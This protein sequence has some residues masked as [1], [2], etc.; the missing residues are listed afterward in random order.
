MKVKIT[1]FYQPTRFSSAGAIA[2]VLLGANLACTDDAR[3]DQL[4]AAQQ[5]PA[6]Q[7]TAQPSDAEQSAIGNERPT[8]GK[9]G[10]SPANETTD[11]LVPKVAEKTPPVSLPHVPLTGDPPE[12]NEPKAE[13]TATETAVGFAAEQIDYFEKHIRPVL[14][15]RCYECHSDQAEVASGGLRVDTRSGLLKGGITGPAVVPG[16]PQKSLILAAI[17]HVDPDVAMPPKDSGEKLPEAVAAD[18]ERWIKMGAPDPRAGNEKAVAYDTE[19]AKQWWAFQPVVLPSVPTTNDASWPLTDIDRYILAALEQRGLTPVADAE[20]STLLRRVYLDLIGLPPSIE[21]QEQFLASSDPKAFER[22]VNDLL[23]RRQFGE[24]WG[25][26][27]LDVA[28][29]AET[30]GR[31]VNLTMPEA[32]RY[33][34]YVIRAWNEDVPFDQFIRQQI[35]GDLL[36]SFGAAERTS[37]L[38]ATGFL[39][40]GPKGLNETDPRQFA[41][42]LADEQIATVSQAFL[43]MTISCARCHDHEFDPITQRDYT[44]LAGIFLSTETHYGTP[45][46]VRGRNASDLVQVPETAGL[47]AVGRSMDPDEYAQKKRQLDQ[48]IQRRDAALR[49]RAP[50]RRRADGGNNDTAISGF[51]IV[52]MMTRAKQIESELAAFNPDGSAKPLVM[53]VSDKPSTAS[54]S[55]RPGRPIGGPNTRGRTSSGF[56]TIADCPLFLRGSIE[57]ESETVPRGLPEF[58][59]RDSDIRIPDDSSGRLELADWIASGENPL[60]SRVIVNRVWHWLFGRGFVESVDNFGT[61]GTPPSNPELLDHLASEFVADGWSVKR[62]IRRIVLSRVYQLD[63][64]HNDAN[65][66]IDPDN[67]LLW[68]ANARRLDAE[69][70]RDSILA[71]SGQLD[72]DPVIGSAIARA[73]DGPVGGDRFQAIREEQIVSAKGRYRSVYLP[74][75]RSVQPE[76]L[77]V[78]DFA[79]PSGVLGARDTTIVPPQALYMLNGDFVQELATAM[80]QRVIGEPDFDSRFRTACRLAY[81]REPFADESAAARRLE[82]DDL[83]TWTSICRALLSSADFLFVD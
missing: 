28:R 43:G 16:N 21:E 77:A 65:H 2:A 40:V 46:G 53:G 71:A 11:A 57:S 62:L 24:R 47:V 61:T 58:L 30:T 74:I 34:D 26:H 10:Q 29:Y 45:G 48:I 41:V 42:E 17:R 37:N 25:R 3:T 31:D 18:F 83:V 81:C 1:C 68:K 63:S 49:D 73:G 32:W 12:V 4:S 35:A 69:T 55:R 76:A 80:A 59:S 60:T 70:I 27:W 54:G 7:A 14:V 50:R 82:G 6:T 56:E 38:I 33:R 44:A 13:V 8:A 9:A 64:T 20:K 66:A 75:A 19:S 51:D 22:V 5:Q 79:D 72:L 39:A 67:E 52:R 36:R 78:F 23:D 15:T